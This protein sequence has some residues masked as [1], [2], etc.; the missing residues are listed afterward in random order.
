[1]WKEEK[2]VWDES[3]ISKWFTCWKETHVKNMLEIE[4][5][6]KVK[7]DNYETVFEIATQGSSLAPNT[8][9]LRAAQSSRPK[10]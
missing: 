10:F 1:M 6:S 3:S 5:A 9:L 4:L 2:D 8:C 7:S